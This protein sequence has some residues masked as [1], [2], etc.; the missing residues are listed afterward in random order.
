MDLKKII[1]NIPDFPVKGVQFKDISTVLQDPNALKISIDEITKLLE[2]VDFDIVLGPESRGFIFGVPI[3]YNL[4]KGFV[5]I[6][7]PGK[8][9][10]KTISKEYELEYGKNTIEMH[11]DAIK[12][13]DKV[14]IIDDLLATGG[15]SKATIELV[16]QVGG[17]VEA[18]VFLI[19]LEQLNG[20]ELL[21]GYN[22]KS[23]LKY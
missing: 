6:R 7:K 5:P 8:L 14:V 2:G 4:N 23:V 16:E 13:G 18:I 17:T 19:E 10:Y 1:R 15:T 21:K 20:R 12:K 11:I 9:P 3:A 22:V